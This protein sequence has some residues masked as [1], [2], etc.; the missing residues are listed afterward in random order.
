MTGLRGIRRFRGRTILF[1][2]VTFLCVAVS[3]WYSRRLLY[4]TWLLATLPLRWEKDEQASYS[5]RPSFFVDPAA[6]GLDLTFQSYNTN[7]LDTGDGYI[8][9]VPPILHHV[10]LGENA[11]NDIPQ[12]WKDARQSCLDL[13]PGWEVYL[14]TDEKARVLVDEKFPDL[15]STWDQY[16][17]RIQRVDALRYMA[18]YEYGGIVLDMDLE[19]KRSLGPLRRFEFLAPS[20]H[21]T[22]FSISFMMASR[23][24]EFISAIL[25]SLKM[26]NRRWLATPYVTVMFSTGGHFASTIH[27]LQQNRSQYK[28]LTGTEDNP[29]LHTLNGKAST[30]LVNHLGSSSWHTYDAAI[31]VLLGHVFGWT[32]PFLLFGLAG[33][34]LLLF[35]RLFQIHRIS[36]WKN[37]ESIYRV[38]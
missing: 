37:K 3:V 6:D 17:Y 1:G 27:T 29:T 22:G 13:H 30:P 23:G 16:P 34:W 11:M 35:H 25:Q 4:L 12:D 36:K 26:Y 32:V 7:Q 15:K 10:V 24:N 5:G 19:C 38:A 33:F 9:R 28:V 2:C 31:I 18:L 21:P 14:W 8:N 20:A